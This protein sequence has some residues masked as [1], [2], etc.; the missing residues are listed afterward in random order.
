M[1]ESKPYPQI[2]EEDGSCQTA[3]EPAVA[4]AEPEVQAIPDDVEY[5]H[6]V[7]GI[8]QVTPDIEEDIVAVDR[9]ET[10]SM[11]EFKNMFARWL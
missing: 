7:N 9:G 10:V 2:E 3:Q 6:I 5:A 4:L 1:K 11:S 8:L